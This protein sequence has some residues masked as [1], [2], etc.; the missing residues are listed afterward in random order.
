MGIKQTKIWRFF[1]SVKLAVWLLAIIATVSL[2]GTLIPQKEEADT[3]Y[4]SWWFIL[5]LI[6][7]TGNLS[8]CLLNRFSLKGRALGSTIA[9][10]GVLV[11]LLGSFIGMIY[12]QKGFMKIDKAKAADYFMSGEKPVYL[13]FSVRLDDFI[14]KENTDPKEKLLVYRLTQKDHAELGPGAVKESGP[15]RP[16]AWISA[17]IGTTSEIADTGYRL[18]V[19]RYIPDFVMDTATKA[20][21]SRSTKPNN[22][23]LEVQIT[24]KEGNARV[25]WVF[26][27]YPDI[28]EGPER[29][30]KFVYK[31]APRRPADFVSRA[32]I[33]KDGS[34]VM[35]GDIR[36]NE[37]LHFGGYTFFQSSYD[38]DRLSWSGLRVVNDPGVGVVYTGFVMLIAGL[39]MIFYVNPFIRRR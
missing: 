38:P 14:Y 31:W 23:A 7:F 33:L 13:G 17:A 26:A 19:L 20:V 21:L 1:S 11:I 10:L 37:P 32:T 15:D 25:F 22:P 24:D 2:S 39:I 30:F 12:G 29:D 8:A 4:S 9:H 18:K 3:L 6:L 34:P 16:I 35:V 36:V 28:H 27:R 5:L